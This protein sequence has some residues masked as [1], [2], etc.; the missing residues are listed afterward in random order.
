M[1]IG[2]AIGEV[3]NDEEGVRTMTVL[4]ENMA[5]QLGKLGGGV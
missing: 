3:E 2:R 4:G 1:G 5:W